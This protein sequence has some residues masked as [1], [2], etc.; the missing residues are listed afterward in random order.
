[1]DFRK[2]WQEELLNAVKA[3]GSLKL[4]VIGDIVVDEHVYGLTSRISR[5]APVLIL[6][7]TERILEIGAAGNAFLNLV[8]LGAKT[9]L[10]GVLGDDPP[11]LTLLE[12]FAQKGWDLGGI[13]VLKGHV[14][15][16]L[17][18]IWAGSP[19]TS[20]QQVIRLDQE[21]K[22]PISAETFEAL[23]GRLSLVL[24]TGV[25]GVIL[26]DYGRGTIPQSQRKDL[27]ALLG[28]HGIPVFVDSRKAFMGYKGAG[29]FFPSEAEAE[30]SLGFKINNDPLTIERAGLM[31]L[32]GLGDKT[33]ALVI[34]LGSMG[35]ALF[36]PGIGATFFEAMGPT[37][38]TDV[39]GA[40]D[41]VTAVFALGT[42]AGLSPKKAAL[43]SD[44]AGGLVVMKRGCAQLTQK[45]LIDGVNRGN[46]CLYFR[47][48]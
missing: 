8:K 11:A 16:K 25:D 13:V 31:L 10:L 46:G 23:L 44:I 40:G 48:G 42:L 32:D 47:S 43:L 18:R 33:R 38:V 21:T 5:E 45:G 17:T 14:T 35:M 15:P 9:Q 19:H 28:K 41:T 39:T 29:Y 20:P 36:E 4:A 12:S 26:A 3:F 6:Q 27:M 7:E 24:A 22:T 1:V 30:E 34:T 2:E 37:E